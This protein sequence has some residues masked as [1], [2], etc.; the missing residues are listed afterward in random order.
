[1]RARRRKA[2]RVAEAEARER[3]R[4]EAESAAQQAALPAF[5]NDMPPNADASFDTKLERLTTLAD[6]EPERVAQII[7]Q[8]IG[9][10]ASAR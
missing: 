1:M 6:G 8:W 9:T 3:S 7:K 5:A 2:A 4:R 10:H